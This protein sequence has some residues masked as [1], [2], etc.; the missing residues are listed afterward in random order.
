MHLGDLACLQIYSIPATT[1]LFSMTWRARI[2]FRARRCS[3]SFFSAATLAFSAVELATPSCLDELSSASPFVTVVWLSDNIF[4]IDSAFCSLCT[5][6][7]SVGSFSS[8]YLEKCN[9]VDLQLQSR[10]SVQYWLTL[11]TIIY[12][13]V[14]LWSV[15]TISFKF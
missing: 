1:L 11:A 9:L 15:I 7:S 12:E 6:S 2:W 14:F 13:Q 3:R 5:R 8:S 4:R 10:E